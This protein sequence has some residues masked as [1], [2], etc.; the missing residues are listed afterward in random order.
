MMV[1]P[2]VY[3][4]P[5][6]MAGILLYAFAG[7]LLGGIDNPLG[8]VLGGF[9]VGIIENLA[10]AYLVGT[11][12]KLTVA[13]IIIVVGA[14]GE[15]VRP[16]GPHRAEQG[17]ADGAQRPVGS[18]GVARRRVPADLPVQRLPPVPA[19]HGHRLC[20]RHPRAGHPDRLQRPDLAGPRCVLCD[21]RLRHRRPDVQVR[22]ALL[23]DAA[24]LGDRLRGG[25]LPD[26]PA[27]AAAGRPVS[28][29]DHL[30]ACRRGAAAS[31]ARRARAVDRRR[32]GAGHRQTRPAVRPRSVAGP[33]ALSVHA[34]SSA[35]CCSCWRGTSCAGASAAR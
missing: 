34:C 15:T 17:V 25:W 19:H 30:R 7:A 28:R 6:M 9:A 21:R 12:L 5:N 16:A 2:I 1:A 33:V 29:A 14:G 4:D 22:R 32:A 24:G 26:R 23:G 31:E 35:R 13:L 3:L 27:G 10:G 11:E 20:D 8:A 18:P